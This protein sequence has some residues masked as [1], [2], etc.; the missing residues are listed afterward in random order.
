[1]GG[2]VNRLPRVYAGFD[3]SRSKNPAQTDLKYYFLLRA[4]QQQGQLAGSFVD[5]HGL[6]PAGKPADLRAE[7]ERRLRQSDLL[8]LILTER[9]PASAG[10]LSWEIERGADACGLPIVCAYP[11]HD[12][13]D[14]RAGRPACWPLA[15]RRV[16]AAGVVPV[17]H[18]PFRAKA[19]GQVLR[20]RWTNSTISTS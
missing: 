19:L 5:V 2:G 4:W 17:W 6:A 7:L 12:T 1:V 13:V 11:G 20:G 14:A 15:L 10:W 8:L 16:A 3:A 9:T 18:L